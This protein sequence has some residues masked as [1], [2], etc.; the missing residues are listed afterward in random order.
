MSLIAV[1][2]GK[3]PPQKEHKNIA[4]IHGPIDD[5]YAGHQRIKGYQRAIEVNNI[6]YNDEYMEP[7]HYKFQDGYEGVKRLLERKPDITAVFCAN[8]EMAIG[9]IKGIVDM[10]MR[11]PEDIAV[12]G[13]DDIDIAKVFIPS[14]TTVHQPFEKKGESAMKAV[15]SLLKGEDVEMKIFHEHKIIKRESTK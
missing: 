13:F 1:N 9:A 7:G 14:L 15:L 3:N 11:V 4:M 10:G 5:P 2:R 8:D 12:A 6:D